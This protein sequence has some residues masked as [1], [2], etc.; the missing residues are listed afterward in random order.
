[1][2]DICHPIVS[3]QNDSVLFLVIQFFITTCYFQ[4][5]NMSQLGCNDQVKLTTAF[6]VYVELCEG[7]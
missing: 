2:Y 4:Y 7:K 1:M 5:Y 3:F 6:Y